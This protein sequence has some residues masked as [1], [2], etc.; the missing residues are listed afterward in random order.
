MSKD[1]K[2]ALVT[3]GTG[4]IG[5]AIIRRFLKDGIHI[6]FTYHNND[7]KANQLVQELQTTYKDLKIQGYRL[8]IT[9]V[10]EI[11]KVVDDIIRDYLQIDILVNN[12]GL[13]ND[14]LLMLMRDE[15]WNRVID[16]NLSGCFHMIS[17]V[18]PYMIERRSGNILNISS[19]SGMVGIKG[20]TNYAASKAGIIALTKSL[21]KEVA[22][23]NIRVNAIAPG[24]INTEMT[25]SL[26]EKALK[27]YKSEIPM[28]R[29]G[30]AD[31]VAS[32]ARFISSEEA[33]Y[34][35]GQ[36]LVIDGGLIS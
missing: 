13:V 25:A 7:E 15:Q 12:A 16:T 31:E 26:T 24:Y 23:K 6:A 18:L 5:E 17:S 29:F 9:Q 36:T 10:S 8:N 2:V 33:S 14:N 21:S 19:V 28:G 11:K 3:G 32:L 30:E 35:T 1:K 20:Q 22:R 34:I 4:G 27:Q